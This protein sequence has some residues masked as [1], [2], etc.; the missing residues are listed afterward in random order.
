MLCHAY[1]TLFYTFE[2]SRVPFAVAMRNILGSTA[3]PSTARFEV[4]M[5]ASGPAG[6]ADQPNLPAG[7]DLIADIDQIFRVV[8][9]ARH[10]TATMIDFDQIAVP[11]HN[12][13]KNHPARRRRVNR[14]ASRRRN[15]DA[16]MK[17]ALAVERIGAHT[18][19]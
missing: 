4:K 18:E 17:L 11:R 19:V 6:P 2:L 14:R 8:A 7:I 15:I 5:I 16:V 10:P 3:R 12:T 1:S 9:V 13:A